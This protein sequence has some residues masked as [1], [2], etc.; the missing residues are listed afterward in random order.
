[1]MYELLRVEDGRRDDLTP[2]LS[3]LASSD[4]S[5]QRFAARALGR[6]ERPE[7]GAALM[8][9][10]SASDP[11]LR[12]EAANALGTLG[13]KGSSAAPEVE[14]AIDIMITRLNDVLS[15][16]PAL[17]GAIL[18]ANPQATFGGGE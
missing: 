16:D 11:H 6:L 10:L 5:V 17:A 3:A 15:Y 14:P 12:R 4:E 8:L 13:R 18:Q 9:L 7:H 1:M 2:L